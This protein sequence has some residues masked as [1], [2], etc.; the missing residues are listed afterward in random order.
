MFI[1]KLIH[2]VQSQFVRQMAGAMAGALIALAVYTAYTG[3]QDAVRAYLA[4]PESE[5]GD[6]AR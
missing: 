5:A 6:I 1:Q 3:A 4:A 2:I